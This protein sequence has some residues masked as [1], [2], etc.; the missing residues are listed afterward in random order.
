MPSAKAL[1]AK[2]A[3]VADL[4]E[5]FSKA[6]A[7][8]LVDYRGLTVE[9]DTKLRSELRKAGVEYKVLK[10][11]LI[12]FAIDGTDLDELKDV[13]ENPTALALSYD[14][15]I[16]PAKVISEFAA[17][18]EALEIKKGFLEGKVVDKAEVEELGKIPPKDMLIAK[19]LGGLNSPIV[20]FVMVLS[21]IA[22]KLEAEAAE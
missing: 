21:Q 6:S 22:K 15:P 8:V 13:L 16:A 5:K 10:N 9:Q 17:K 11:T 12:R 20:G 3:V 7:G 14:D 1:E 4:T 18:N 2:K 19:A